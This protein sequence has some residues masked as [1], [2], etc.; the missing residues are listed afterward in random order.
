MY[1]LHKKLLSLI[2]GTIYY[3]VSSEP[4]RVGLKHHISVVIQPPPQVHVVV[5]HPSPVDLKEVSEEVFFCNI[6]HQQVLTRTPPLCS[7]RDA[8]GSLG[9]CFVQIKKQTQNKDLYKINKK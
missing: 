3:L 5:L 8:L 7:S 9:R 6:S 1:V 4:L 2:V